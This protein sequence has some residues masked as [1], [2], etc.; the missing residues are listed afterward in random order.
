MAG[1]SG[2]T[3][4]E[5][6]AS[7]SYVG[8][9]VGATP[10]GGAWVGSGLSEH[11][12]SARDIDRASAVATSAVPHDLTRRVCHLALPNLASREP[13]LAGVPS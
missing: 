6:S 1:T 10:N 7:P 8:V 9:P 2:S 13:H 3:A 4:A 11:P 12:A 5:A